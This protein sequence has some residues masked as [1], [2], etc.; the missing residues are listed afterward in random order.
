MWLKF[1]IL[2]LLFFILALIQNSFLPHFN[3]MGN[4]PN[5]IFIL[6]FILIF[7]EKDNRYYEGILFSI[8]AGFILDVLSGSYFGDAIISLLLVYILIKI[9]IYFLKE[10]QDKN[11]LFY[12]IPIFLISLASYEVLYNLS[13]DFYNLKF[14]ILSAHNWQNILIGF[15]YNLMVAFFVFFVYKKINNLFLLN[16]NRQLK[17]F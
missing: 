14:N 3:I 2:I 17:L 7:F 12:F 8:I 1:L 11:L 6:F 5:L 13:T 15:G 9:V 10:R 16:K 4:S